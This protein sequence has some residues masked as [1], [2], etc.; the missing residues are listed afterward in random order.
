MN[1]LMY[2]FVATTKKKQDSCYTDI[3][4]DA[5]LRLSN[6]ARFLRHE[7]TNFHRFKCRV[8]LRSYSFD[9]PLQNGEISV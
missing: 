6:K 5:G 4:C 2:R 7:L 8:L 9:L 3:T 1:K